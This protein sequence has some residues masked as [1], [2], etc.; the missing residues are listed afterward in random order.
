MG[1]L[2]MREFGGARDGCEICILACCSGYGWWVVVG[3]E[4]PGHLSFQH[5]PTLDGHKEK[6][7]GVIG[8]ARCVSGYGSCMKEEIME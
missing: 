3:F 7:Q 4:E 1:L 5:L 6:V 8:L 2:G